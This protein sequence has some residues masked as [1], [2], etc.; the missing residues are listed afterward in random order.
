[1]KEGSLCDS[2][3]SKFSKERETNETYA[4]FLGEI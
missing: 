4:S 2:K 1:M 3:S